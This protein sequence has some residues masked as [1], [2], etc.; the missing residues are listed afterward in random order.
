MKDL[1]SV[2]TLSFLLKNLIWA[3]GKSTKEDYLQKYYIHFYIQF[4]KDY[5]SKIFKRL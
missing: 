2:V 1:A 4:C 3:G 5:Y